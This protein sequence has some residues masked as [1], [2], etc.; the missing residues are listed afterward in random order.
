[1]TAPEQVAP[2]TVDQKLS[3]VAVGAVLSHDELPPEITAG[4]VPYGLQLLLD[5]IKQQYMQFIKH[6]QTQ[7]FRLSVERDI[8]KE[9]VSMA[10]A[11]ATAGL[12]L[13]IADT[14][15]CLHRFSRTVVKK[16]P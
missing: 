2:G 14:V 16:S 10:A 9:R 6:M 13:A 8:E 11:V 7:D 1:M 3:S 12:V 5:S 15:R 4:E